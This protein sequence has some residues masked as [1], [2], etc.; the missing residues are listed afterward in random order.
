[1]HPSTHPTEPPGPPE[2]TVVGALRDAVD[3]VLAWVGQQSA[4]KSSATAPGDQLGQALVALQHQRDRLDVATANLATQW[5]ASGAWRQQQALSAP[6]ALATE[7]RQ[8]HRRLQQDFHHARRLQRMP[9][10]RAAILDGSLSTDH[11]H[12]FCRF[13]T[14][15]RFDHFLHDEQLLVEQCSQLN[16]FDDC[17]KVLAYWAAHVD[18]LLDQPPRTPE[19]S[20]IFASRNSYTGELDVNGV[21]SAIDADIV[22]NELQRL[23]T[24]IRHEDRAA[25]TSRSAA[26]RRAMALVRMAARS[27]GANGPTPRPLFQVVVGDQT[28][29]RLCE[30]GSGTVV[31]PDHL[32]QYLHTAV[33]ESFLFDTD[34]TILGVSAKRSFAG[35]LRRAI[36]VRDRRCQHP[37]GCPNPAVG[38]DIDH[39][40]PV[41]L[42]GETSQFNGRV[43]CVAHNRNPELRDDETPL[44]SRSITSR[45]LA[46]NMF[47]WQIEQPSFWQVL[48]IRQ[49][50][51]DP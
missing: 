39:I 35:R 42:G 33:V 20:R 13:A 6:T 31:G 41:S 50:R 40:V 47:R 26:Q 48:R 45:D 14:P 12:L 11:L 3:G 2:L 37:S 8:C 28:L 38:G 10:T 22:H 25:G 23:I 44:P 49:P 43:L 29:S 4:A 9:H 7:T 51:G 19:P 27:A 46:C 1:M 32:Q 36:E 21:L 30:L 18:A 24:G 17:R 16:V 15:R 5:E 34:H